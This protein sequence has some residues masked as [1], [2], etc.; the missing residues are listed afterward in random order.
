M[1]WQPDVPLIKY[2]ESPDI[3]HTSNV[4]T[5]V[6]FLQF[7]CIDETPEAGTEETACRQSS[8]F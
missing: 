3:L 7:E 4:Q 6:I 1:P 2:P 5:L 8:S